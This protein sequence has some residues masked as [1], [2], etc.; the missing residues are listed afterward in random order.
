MC[1]CVWSEI[2]L[3]RHMS[4]SFPPSPD[5][6]DDE[7]VAIADAPRKGRLSSFKAR[8]VKV[9]ACCVRCVFVCSLE[10]TLTRHHASQA[11]AHAKGTVTHMRHPSRES[12]ESGG[13]RLMQPTV[14]MCVCVCECCCAC[15]VVVIV[16]T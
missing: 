4:Y 14:R 9:C 7:V 13:V 16:I 11:T 3:H 5:D 1:V 8:I 2:A 12:K 15:D 6:E 10:C